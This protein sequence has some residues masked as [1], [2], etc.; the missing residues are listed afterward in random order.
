[1][2]P[3]YVGEPMPTLDE[4]KEG[5]REVDRWLMKAQDSAQN[6]EGMIRVAINQGWDAAERYTPVSRSGNTVKIYAGGNWTEPEVVPFDRVMHESTLWGD[7][8]TYAV[9]QATRWR[10]DRDLSEAR[11][12]KRFGE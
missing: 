5:K 10:S 11:F 6:T 7:P 3:K 1:M 4:L 12:M 9:K 2:D 8:G